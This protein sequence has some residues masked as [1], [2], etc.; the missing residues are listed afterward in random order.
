MSPTFVAPAAQ[1]AWTTF[2]M[3]NG[4]PEEAKLLKE[5]YLDRRFESRW[6]MF[7][8]EAGQAVT[9]YNTAMMTKNATLATVSQLL[10]DNMSTIPT[11]P[12]ESV[13]QTTTKEKKGHKTK[14][15]SEKRGRQTAYVDPSVK[16]E[17]DNTQQTD[18]K[19][20]LTAG[21]KSE[22]ADA[23]ATKTQ[24]TVDGS[25]SRDAA[26][27]APQATSV[28]VADKPTQSTTESKTPQS[29]TDTQKTDLPAAPTSWRD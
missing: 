9:S 6:K 19:S 29:G 4:G 22:S 24:G 7:N 23:A 25:K 5:I 2:V 8:Q 18:A 21:T 13:A 16:Q 26:Q 14:T 3:V 27:A 28:E 12:T 15:A 11:G 20:S 10:L 17:T 1:V